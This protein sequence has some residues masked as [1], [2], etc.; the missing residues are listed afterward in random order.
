MKKGI[1]EKDD[2]GLSVILF[3]AQHDPPFVRWA[4][5]LVVDFMLF[6]NGYD[7]IYVEHGK[8]Q[9]NYLVKMTNDSK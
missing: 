4:E 7:F 8:R 6:E 5:N 1:P 3:H 2:I 9:K